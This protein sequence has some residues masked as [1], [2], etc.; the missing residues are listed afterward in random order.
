MIYLSSEFEAAIAAEL[1]QLLNEKWEGF[2]ETREFYDRLD[3][4]T[5]AE[6]DLMKPSFAYESSGQNLQLYLSPPENEAKRYV[7]LEA[8]VDNEITEGDGEHLRHILAR[9]DAMAD[10]VREALGT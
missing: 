9:L 2:A 5:Q 4:A 7:D 8:I 1:E 3:T 6:L 10:R